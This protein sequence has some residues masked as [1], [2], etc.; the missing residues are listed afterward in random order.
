M[1]LSTYTIY[2]TDPELPA[3][4][5]V[6]YWYDA[7]SESHALEQWGLDHPNCKVIDI[8]N[9]GLREE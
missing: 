2:F 1:Q 3:N 7:T 6:C 5:C 4:L 8:T 9:V